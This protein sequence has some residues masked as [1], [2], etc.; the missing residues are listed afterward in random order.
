MLKAKK[1]PL[2]TG[3]KF[4]SAKFKNVFTKLY[5]IEHSKMRDRQCRLR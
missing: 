2:K 5:H 1:K 4:T 3:L